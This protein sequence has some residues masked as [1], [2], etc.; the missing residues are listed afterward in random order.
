MLNQRPFDQE[1]GL[2]KI[3]LCLYSPNY[4]CIH[5]ITYVTCDLQLFN[6][7]VIILGMFEEPTDSQ[8]KIL[9]LER[10]QYKY[11]KPITFNIF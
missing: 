6:L 3:Y 10:V 8:M 1:K 11:A 5:P 7:H 9:K 4:M 2:I